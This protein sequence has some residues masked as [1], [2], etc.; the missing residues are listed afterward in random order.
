MHPHDIDTDSLREARTYLVDALTQVG[1]YP[2]AGWMDKW[3]G[4]EL[5]LRIE[6]GN[7]SEHHLLCRP[8]VRAWTHAELAAALEAS[9]LLSY[10]LPDAGL[11]AL[12]DRAVGVVV[13]EAAARLRRIIL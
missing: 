6:G 3:I 10:V 1:V 11:G 5:Q 2:L 7:P 13:I 12:M 8:P 9:T 4:E